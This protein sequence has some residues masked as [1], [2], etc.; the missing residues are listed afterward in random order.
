MSGL[1]SPLFGR[2]SLPGLQEVGRD[3]TLYGAVSLVRVEDIR[4][5][6]GNGAA[7]FDRK[8]EHVAMI[9]TPSPSHDADIENRFRIAGV[10]LPADRTAG[11]Y[12]TA[13]WLISV[14]HWL[15][16]PRAAASEPAHVFSLLEKQ[17][18]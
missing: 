2:C 1:W 18:Q 11:A 4:I 10:V 17:Y 7:Q 14:L 13:Q 3:T 5:E 9:S 16:Q 15:R 6:N 8:L 12:A